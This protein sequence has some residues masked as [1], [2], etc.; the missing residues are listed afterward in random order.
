MTVSSTDC[1][2]NALP[3]THK[4]IPLQAIKP[5]CVLQKAAVAGMCVFS[6]LC[7]GM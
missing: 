6:V 2:P 4:G 3:P 5:T 7:E 1:F